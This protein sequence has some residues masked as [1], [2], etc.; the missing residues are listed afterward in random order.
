MTQGSTSVKMN[1]VDLKLELM[2]EDSETLSGFGF[3]LNWKNID[4]SGVLP[5][6]GIE[7]GIL[8]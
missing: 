3:T 7:I 8:K 6:A 2:I 4:F 1:M 5:T